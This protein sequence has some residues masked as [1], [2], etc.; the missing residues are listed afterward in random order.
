VLRESLAATGWSVVNSTPL[1]V[2]CF[3]REGLVPSQL[4]ADLRERQIAWM[5]DAQVGAVSV[6]RACI[7]SF[8]TTEYEIHW[9]VDQMNK[10]VPDVRHRKTA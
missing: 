10:L 1:P 6:V 8:R 3:T 2:I 7:T 9:V 5:S 4:V